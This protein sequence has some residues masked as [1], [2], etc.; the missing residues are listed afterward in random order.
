MD[1]RQNADILK[2]GVAQIAPVWLNRAA[3]TA[4]ILLHVELAAQAGC[5]VVCFG[6]ALLPGY[7]FWLALTDGARFNSPV[8]KDLHAHYL[9][10]AVQIEAGHLQPLCA[11]AS[12]HRIA[13]VVGCVERPAD[14]GGH[15]LYCS[16][17]C[18]DGTGIL[19][20]V[21]R[22]L[23]PTHEE[24]LVWA[25]GDGHGLRVH[26]L[27]AFTAGGLN[28]WEN[29]MPLARATLHSLGEDL[30]F[31]LWPGSLRN[32][33]EI[34]RFIAREGR[35]FVVSACG[36][37][38]KQDLPPEI[39][40]AALVIAAAPDF[41]ADGGSCIA[42]PEGEW[43]VEPRVGNEELI[44]AT[45]DHRRVRA[46]RQNFDPAGHYSRPDVIQLSLNTRRQSLFA[47]PESQ[48]DSGNGPVFPTG[49][50]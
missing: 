22:K 42:G 7:P 11:A 30:H 2:V 1:D 36:L 3:T 25:A 40:H 37:M 24:R 6:E 49:G 15:S 4:K 18:I 17:V 5:A 13:I 31:A 16:L 10:Q 9:D 39:P 26:S 43:I 38:R 45:L 50:G 47:D 12:R 41:P 32:T 21:H 44:V 8:Q 19:R 46:E 48:R 34:T 33:A 20:T 35:S 29:W 14:R 28:C 27:G 23:V